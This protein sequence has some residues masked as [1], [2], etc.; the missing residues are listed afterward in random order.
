VTPAE[1]LALYERGWR[2]IDRQ[3]MGAAEQALLNRLI[4]EVGHGV[5]NG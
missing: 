1:A 3:H 2:G 4:K 5:F